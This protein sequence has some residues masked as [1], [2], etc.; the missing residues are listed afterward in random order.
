MH[1]WMHSQPY[2]VAL[3][4]S[5]ILPHATRDNE[6]V[7]LTSRNSKRAFQTQFKVYISHSTCKP[8]LLTFWQRWDF[9]SK[10]NPA[11]KNDALVSRLREL[12][13]QNCTQKDMVDTLQSEGFPI[14]DRELIRLRL[15]LNLLLRESV[16][17]PKKKQNANG[18]QKKKTK[19]KQSGPLSG[20][21]LIDQLANAILAEESSAEDES[22]EESQTRPNQDTQPVISEATPNLLSV[23]DAMRKQL[24]QEQLQHD[25]DEKWRTRKRRRRTRGWAGLPADAPGQPPRFPSETTIDESKA[26]LGLDNDMYRQIRERF[27]EICKEQDVIKKTLAGPEKWS[28]VVQLLI[29]G[30]THLSSMFQE[31]PEVLQNDDALFRPKSQ[32]ALSLDVI[33]MD[34]TKRLRT[35][36]NRMTL[37]DAK[38]ALGLNPEQTRNVRSAFASKLKEDH[39][40]NKFEAGE[41]HWTAL[42]QSW[43]NESEILLKALARGESDPNY[44]Q[45]LRAIEVLARD[46]MKRQQ[47]EKVASDPSK[48]KQLHQGPGPGPAPPV[49]TPHSSTLPINNRQTVSMRRE[50]ALQTSYV[51][52]PILPTS[53]DLQIDPSLLLAASDAAIIPATAYEA[54]EHYNPRQNQPSRQQQYYST[55]S[56]QPMPLPVYFRL[57]PN[58]TTSSPSKSVWLSL[59]QTP[60]FAELRNLIIR[61]H[62]DSIINKLEGLITFRNGGQEDNNVVIEIGDD[63]ELNAYLGH[64]R[65]DGPGQGI[66]KAT[67]IVTL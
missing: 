23:E 33:C 40:T 65:G 48:K 2:K 4:H 57:H 26:Y 1:T 19:K 6:Q 7:I 55:P 17:R 35:M 47:Q 15:R 43:V 28:Q 13:G 58:S 5:L 62:P 24:R 39:F 11:H 42:K 67:F 27:L 41:E 31:E 53:S 22:A 12:W 61:E 37:A 66:A 9:P 54:A 20:N 30:S 21:G 52:E 49:V 36:E 60:S 29:R 8:I 14:S 34:V 38:N 56:S 46:V 16:Q 63:D 45:K 25:S 44:T 32:K 50:T 3:Q 59:L 64:I 18:V 10:Q 51:T